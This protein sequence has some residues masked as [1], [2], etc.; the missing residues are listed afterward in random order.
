MGEL[1]VAHFTFQR[2]RLV[3]YECRPTFLDAFVFELL[4]RISSS[5][6]C[7][8]AYVSLSRLAG[9]EHKL[10]FVIIV[11]WPVLAVVCP[12]TCSVLLQVHL[13]K[14]E[15]ELL[16]GS[17]ALHWMSSARFV[18][19][20]TRPTSFFTHCFQ[21]IDCLSGIW[22]WSANISL[23]RPTHLR[24]ESPFFLCTSR[25]CCYLCHSLYISDPSTIT[26][27]ISF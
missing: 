25:T 18:L 7:L 13:L 14:C 15:R 21:L 3:S 22:L 23:T 5:P 10:P 26:G 16:E 12:F 4:Y 11:W 1:F 2:S 9:L 19:D 6:I 27:W 24:S 20:K 17:F 8:I